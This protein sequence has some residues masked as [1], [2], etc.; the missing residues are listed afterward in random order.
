[1]LMTY[2]QGA[3]G[4]K[5]SVG[6]G[7]ARARGRRVAVDRVSNYAV[8]PTPR[9]RGGRAERGGIRTE[10]SRA[11]RTKPRA[12][13]GTGGPFEAGPPAAPRICGQG[14]CNHPMQRA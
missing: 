4:A 10:L 5:R 9:V 8:V 3:R 12:N 7:V 13:Q 6:G 1:M 11:T 2:V 14:G